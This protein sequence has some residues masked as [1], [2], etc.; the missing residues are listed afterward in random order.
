[1]RRV[2]LTP[3]DFPDRVA[4][5]L[6]EGGAVY[7]AERGGKFYLIQDE[8]SMMG[9]LDDEDLADLKDHLVKVLEFDTEAVRASYIRQRGWD[10]PAG[11][12]GD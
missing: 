3:E 6:F 9:I 4:L 10:A 8:R 11:R 1:M 2:T 12:H 5:R 7:T